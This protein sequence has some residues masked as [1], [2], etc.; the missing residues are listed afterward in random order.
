LLGAFN[1][2]YVLV[3]RSPGAFRWLSQKDLSLA[4]TQDRYLILHNDATLDRA[5]LYNDLPL[6]VR[7]LA[8]SDAAL[9]ARR[10]EI[11]RHDVPQRTTSSYAFDDASGPGTVF[12]AENADPGWRATIDGAELDR[13]SGGWGNAW[14][15]PAR[16]D[17]QLRIVYPRSVGDILWLIY[18]FLIWG[19]LIGAAF[20][21][22]RRPA[23]RRAVSQ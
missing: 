22:R 6:Y 2:R 7:A 17:G 23:G 13:A 4:Q 1:V 3:E 9:A 12:L 20:T 18:V 21:R 16:V 19:V 8:E 15:I 11:A 10:P 14:T 5:A